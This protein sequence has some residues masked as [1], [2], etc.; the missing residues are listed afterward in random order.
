MNNS[1]NNRLKLN[2]GDGGSVELPPLTEDFVRRLHPLKLAFVGDA[3][4]EFYIRLY[5]TEKADLNTH[6]MAIEASKYARASAQAIAARHLLEGGASSLISEEERDVLIRG[7]NQK[8]KTAPKNASLADYRYATGLEALIGYL[9]LLGRNDRVDFIVAESIRAIEA[10][11]A[12]DAA[13]LTR[14]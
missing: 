11:G 12:P 1:E 14:H 5:I 10:E 9:S 3:V 8:T 2:I 4:F 6:V 13:A 7:R